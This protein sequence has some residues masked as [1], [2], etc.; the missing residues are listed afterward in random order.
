[1]KLSLTHPVQ[2]ETIFSF[3]PK[4]NIIYFSPTHPPKY[5][6]IFLLSTEG[7]IIE[8]SCYWAV[9]LHRIDF[10]IVLWFE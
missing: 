1:M 2:S 6:I 5:N 3:P 10:I 7:H 8:Y 9:Q 4:W